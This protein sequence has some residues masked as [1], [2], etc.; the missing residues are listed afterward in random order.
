LRLARV[1]AGM[2][3]FAALRMT[4]RRGWGPQSAMRS[5]ATLGALTRFRW[6]RLLRLV[7]VVAGMGSFAALRMTS[8]RVQGAAV[9]DVAAWQTLGGSYAN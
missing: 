1:V 9:G 6:E 3:S 5:V 2:G 7:T 8:C 4:N